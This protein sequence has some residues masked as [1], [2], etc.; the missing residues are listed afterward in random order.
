MGPKNHVA[1]LMG[2]PDLSRKGHFSGIL[3]HRLLR[4]VHGRCSLPN[5]QVAAAMRSLAT[6]T[7]STC[8]YRHYY[9]H[10]YQADRYK[11]AGI[12]LKLRK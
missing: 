2:G 8:Y 12:K 5:S 6:I 3:L 7:L 1:Y 11:V 4:L 10:H 9:Y